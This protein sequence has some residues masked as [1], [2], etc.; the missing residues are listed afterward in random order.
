MNIAIQAAIVVLF[1]SGALLFWQH[2]ISGSKYKSSKVRLNKY[3]AAVVSSLQN[4][5][6][7][8][9]VQYLGLSS[10]FLYQFIRY[11]I[12][13][14]LL[15]YIA[16]RRYFTGED[17]VVSV[18]ISI[19]LFFVTSP[20]RYLFNKDS[21]FFIL[22]TKV[23]NIKK[24]KLNKEIYRCLSQLKNMAIA[25]ANAKYSADYII[26]ELA[27]YTTHTK[28]IFE[29]MLGY[30]YEGRFKEATDYFEQA[31][32]TK[33]SK[34]L[35]SLLSKLD[36]IK[37]AEFI[38]QIELYQNEA[39]E[40]KKTAAQKAR[41]S[42]SSMVFALV[43]LVGILIIVNLFVVVIGVDYTLNRFFIF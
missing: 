5:E 29:R 14:A 38:S 28:P 23:Q 26:C 39:K 31:I 9:L 17:V 42:K 33:D 37:P 24:Q 30:W 7:D 12:F 2:G 35:A 27:K 19:V 36:Y 41:K 20:R 21:P 16:Y 34:T 15:G 13:I 32:G 18:I 6:I 3:K 11:V 40:E 10:G 8:S 1:F 43:M 4:D 25:K 22:I